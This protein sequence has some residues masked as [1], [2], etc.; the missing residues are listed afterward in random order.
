MAPAV[1]SPSTSVSNTDVA[2]AFERVADLLEVQ[3]GNP[4]RVRAYRAAA[5]TMRTLDRPVS[6]LV[7]EEGPDAL[8]RLPGIGTALAAAIEEFV[9]TGRMRFLERLEGQ[10][11]PED[12]LRT[13]PGIGPELAR[14]IHR[15]LGVE[16]LEELE[17]AAH[18][19]RLER[20]RGFGP[21]RT[22]SVRQTLAGILGR[23]ARRRALARGP[24]AGR[25][26]PGR[27]GYQ[28]PAAVPSV[29]ALLSVDEEYRSRARAGELHRIAPRR[30]NPL[31]EAWLPILHTEREGWSMTAL[32]SNTAR[33]HELGRTHDW[34][35]VYADGD[36]GSEQRFTVVTEYQGDLTGRRVVRGRELECRRYYAESGTT[37]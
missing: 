1:A 7:L 8:E 20:V 26:L 32:F 11:C 15:D 17:I 23:A 14:R 4:F 9:L 37:R 22:E 19:G 33:A 24:G 36:H 18:D 35:V 16:T 3:D 2:D 30:F 34:V 6:A 13:I 5:S 28:E 10:V 27:P 31:H 25:A 21:R 12:L 29:E